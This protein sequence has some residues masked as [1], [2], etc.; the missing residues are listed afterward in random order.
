MKSPFVENERLEIAELKRSFVAISMSLW[1]QKDIESCWGPITH[2]FVFYFTENNI[3]HDGCQ[4]WKG[5]FFFCLWH[6]CMYLTFFKCTQMWLPCKSRFSD[7]F[8]DIWV[9]QKAPTED[10]EIRLI[11]LF[12]F[13]GHFSV[14]CSLY[15]CASWTGWW[16]K[17]ITSEENCAPGGQ[18]IF[19]LKLI[20]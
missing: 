10:R 7:F 20:M 19:E 16:C 15:H 1:R 4:D 2:I 18:V 13:I 9:S 8:G 11:V 12:R 14:F 6:T 3:T 17:Y 5:C